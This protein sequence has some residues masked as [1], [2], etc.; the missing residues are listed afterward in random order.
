M[1]VLA[2]KFRA[3]A[4]FPQKETLAGPMRI[5]KT[6]R[7]CRSTTELVRLAVEARR[8]FPG[9]QSSVRETTWLTEMRFRHDLR[10]AVK[11]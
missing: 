8:A 4:C 6:K 7:G 3:R 5:R 11:S 1:S 9:L 10:V 2:G